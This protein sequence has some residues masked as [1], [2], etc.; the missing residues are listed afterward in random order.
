MAIGESRTFR[1]LFVSTLLGASLA[2]IV[3]SA[4]L[5]WP[6][7]QKHRAVSALI[8]G[9]KKSP[10]PQD[11]PEIQH[12][13]GV[14][15]EVEAANLAVT[16]LFDLLHDEDVEVR[17]QAAGYIAYWSSEAPEALPVVVE[18]LRGDDEEV[19]QWLLHNFDVYRKLVGRVPPPDWQDWRRTRSAESRLFA[20]KI[21]VYSA[22][23]TN[24]LCPMLIEEFKD[25]EKVG[26]QVVAVCNPRDDLLDGN[27][28]IPLLQNALDDNDARIRRAA[29]RAL[30]WLEPARIA[31]VARR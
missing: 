29:A 18:I 3:F 16:S 27:N 17:K 11:D 10:H 31:D 6:V 12:C 5:L 2:T 7:W 21:L 15:N 20:L 8:E 19:A 26:E 25:D 9:I 1:V 23:L 28:L 13:V 4:V 14:V 30:E 24:R 22:W